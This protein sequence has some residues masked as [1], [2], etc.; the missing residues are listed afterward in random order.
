MSV[1][2]QNLLSKPV[3]S[4]K[5]PQALPAG[6]YFA[7]I[8]SHKF[9]ESARQ[10]TPYVRFEFSDLQPG[11]DIDASQLREQD[12]TPIDLSKKKLRSDFYLTDDAMYRLREFLEGLGIPTE[13]RSFGET[14]PETKGL[15][16]QLTVTMRPAEGENAREGTFYNDVAQVSKAA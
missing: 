10:K 7:R 12:G 6:T 13:G 11:Q 5:R 4:A 2:F 16:V 8:A 3:D 15:P 1:N 9:D 14:I